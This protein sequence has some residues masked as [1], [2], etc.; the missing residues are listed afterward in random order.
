MI[1]ALDTYMKERNVG[2]ADMAALIARD[3]SVVSKIR[4]GLMRPTLDV[5][6]RI[7]TVTD[8]AVPMQAWAAPV[9]PQATA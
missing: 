5:A 9:V 3:R 6:A 8:G 4:R 7:E 1:T 2:D